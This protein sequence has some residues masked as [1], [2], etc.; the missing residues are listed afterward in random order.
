MGIYDSTLGN[1]VRQDEMNRSEREGL[2]SGK[3]ERFRELE[4]RN[5]GVQVEYETY[6]F[7]IDDFEVVFGWLNTVV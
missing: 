6:R 5:S 4:R 2:T 3:R 7:P 1:W